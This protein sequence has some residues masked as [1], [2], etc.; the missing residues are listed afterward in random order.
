MNNYNLHSLGWHSFQQLCLTILREILGQTVESF[1]DSKDG[2]RDGA[3]AGTWVVGKGESLKGKFVIQ[4]KFTAKADKSL[5][6]SDIADEVG[7]AKRL[8]K[9]KL[10][11]SYVLLTNLNVSG[12]A[13]EKLNETFCAV[14]VKQFRC[15]GADWINQQIRERKRLR[16]LV[17]RIYG[18]GDLSQILDGRALGQAQALLDSMREDLSRV[19]LTGVYDKA[20]RALDSH[21]FV[22]LLGEPASGKTT[23]AAM[24]AM[25]AIDQWNASTLKLETAPQ[26]I[27]HWNTEDPARFYWIDDAFGVQQFEQDLVLEWNR[28]FPKVKAMINGGAR[29]VLTSRDYIYRRAKQTLKESAFPLMQESQV[30]INVHEITTKERKQILYNHIKL[31]T[32]P[33]RFRSQ[34]KPYLDQVASHHRFIPETARRLGDPLFTRTLDVSQERVIDF[35]ERQEQLLQEVIEG[36]DKHSKAALALIFIRNGALESPVKPREPEI[37][38]LTR[39]GTELGETIAALDALKGSLTV[40]V[41]EEGNLVW[42]FKHPTVGDAYASILLRN[43]ELMDIYI[44]GARPEQ[45][46]DAITCG[47]VGFEGAV[48]IPKNLYESVEQ[49]LNIF[50]DGI[51]SQGWG[52]DWAK[53]RK[54]DIFLA[55]RCDRLFLEL[56]LSRHAGILDRISHPGSRLDIVSEVV[57]ALR[58]FELGLLPE[59]YRSRFVQ[60]VI[61]YAVDGEDGFALESKRI[62]KMFTKDEKKELKLRLRKELIPSLADARNGWETN[63]PE[64]EDPES[65]IQ[66]LEELLSALERTFSSDSDIVTAVRKEQFSVRR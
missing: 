38:A 10:C 5:N 39:L 26:M 27:D 20:V 31:G 4:C 53:R 51:A 52:R 63:L 54:L 47:E 40:Q 42:R 28:I 19:V 17:P 25:A 61:Q 65:Y 33:Q 32:Q 8:V 2:G 30:V 3:F 34:I 59:G 21:G 36:L 45:L 14:G 66:P 29:I 16:M 11:E 58:F 35:V 62:K 6:L 49:K 43:S 9:K 7:K 12:A 1:L 24:L 37:S 22:L 18:L 44:E 55:F 48:V 64:D 23:I 15:F 13:H 50:D 41:R 57:V 56:Y 60:T 46:L